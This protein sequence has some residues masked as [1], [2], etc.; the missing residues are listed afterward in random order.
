MSSTAVIQT[1]ITMKFMPIIEK[2]IKEDM[3][4]V[5]LAV[6]YFIFKHFREIFRYYKKYATRGKIGVTLQLLLYR[7]KQTA[8]T[9]CSKEM[10]AILHDFHKNKDTYKITHF[11]AISCAD[12][13]SNEN[14]LT[15]SSVDYENSVYIPTQDKFSFEFQTPDMKTPLRVFIKKTEEIASENDDARKSVDEK[16]TYTFDVYSLIGDI[17]LFINHCNVQYAKYEYDKSNQFPLIESRTQD[18]DSDDVITTRFHSNKTFDTVFIEENIMREIKV[19]ITDVL[20]NAPYF[21]K[22]GLTRKFIALLHGPPGT[23]KSS[24]VKASLNFCQSFD[25]V[26][27]I[28]RVDLSII[29]D[30]DEL[31]D[32]FIDSNAKIIYLEEVDRAKCIHILKDDSQT[33]PSIDMDKL[34]KMQKDEILEQIEAF[35]KSSVSYS[36]E[37]HNIKIEDILELFDGLPELDGFIILM[38]TN[39]IDKIEPRFRRRCR[40]FYIGNQSDELLKKQL[41]F[42]YEC[43][44]YFEKQS[45]ELP[46]NTWTGCEIEKR[47][48]R[49]PTYPTIETAIKYI[50]EY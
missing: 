34:K 40:E 23:G 31:F 36:N 13:S 17:Q 43:P 19:G 16:T 10:K 27:H 38:T 1:M 39:N 30:K 28:K 32:M 37:S 8:K 45:I 35:S 22:M 14:W 15:L 48:L 12:T 33:N 24:I 46:S 25:K 26:R 6:G 44:G 47:F 4:C 20:T 11:T 2:L 42:Y 41:E 50:Q 21:E 49:N 9:H 18:K 29:K 3:K 7:N 5:L